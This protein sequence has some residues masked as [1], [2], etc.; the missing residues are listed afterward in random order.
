MRWTEEVVLLKEE[1]CQVRAFFIW[2]AGWWERKASEHEVP[3]PI[4]QEGIHAYATRQSAQRRAMEARCAHMWQNILEF[5]DMFFTPYNPEYVVG[6]AR[7]ASMVD[8]V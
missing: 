6:S 2:H 7:E 8:F 1:M 4:L 3:D 5:I